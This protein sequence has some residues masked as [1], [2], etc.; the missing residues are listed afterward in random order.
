[1]FTKEADVAGYLN[2]KLDAETIERL[3]LYSQTEGQSPEALIPKII[4][5]YLDRVY[6]ESTHADPCR[7]I[8]P[9]APVV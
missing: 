9:S 1:M 4:E 5:Q 6:E 3:C 2:I 7:Q 8:C